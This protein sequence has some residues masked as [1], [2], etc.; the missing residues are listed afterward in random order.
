MYAPID[1]DPLTRAVDGGVDGAGTYIAAHT[2]P[3]CVAGAPALYA[4]A[5]ADR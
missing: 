3:A 1:F 5:S 4:D 2:G